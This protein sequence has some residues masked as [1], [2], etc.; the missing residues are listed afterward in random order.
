[1]SMLAIG[2]AWLHFP[3]H[4][5]IVVEAALIDAMVSITSPCYVPLGYSQML[6]FDRRGWSYS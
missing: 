6:W 4:N 3:I 2:D 1:M 5:Y